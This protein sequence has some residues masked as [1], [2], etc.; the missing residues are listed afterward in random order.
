MDAIW[1]ALDKAKP[2]RIAEFEKVDEN[3]LRNNNKS[4]DWMTM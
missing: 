4:L 3:N 1:T 2:C